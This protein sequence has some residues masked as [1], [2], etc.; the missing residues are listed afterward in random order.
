[1]SRWSKSKFP[2][3]HAEHWDRASGAVFGKSISLVVPDMP[4]VNDL[5]K[6]KP[7]DGTWSVEMALAHTMEDDDVQRMVEEYKRIRGEL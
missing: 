6:A 4:L 5:A 2:E 7:M 3:K 1:M